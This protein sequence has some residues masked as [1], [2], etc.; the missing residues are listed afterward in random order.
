MTTI[1]AYGDVG[2]QENFIGEV[3][4]EGDGRLRKGFC[5]GEG[6][7]CGLEQNWSIAGL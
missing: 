7:L 3:S 2:L 5:A 4:D 1:V 6:A